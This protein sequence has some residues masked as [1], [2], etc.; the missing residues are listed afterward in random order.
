MQQKGAAVV[1]GAVA[2]VRHD[3]EIRLQLHDLLQRG[4]A[5]EIDA[6]FAG[7]ICQARLLEDRADKTVAAGHP[8]APRQWQHAKMP[9]ACE[10]ARLRNRGIEPRDFRS[11]PLGMTGDVAHL[12]DLL[13]HLAEC[14][15]HRQFDEIDAV[16]LQQ[17]PRRSLVELARGDDIG[18]QHQNVL[19]ASRQD[20]KFLRAFDPAQRPSRENRLKPMICAGSAS[21]SSIWS[22]QMFIDTMR[23]AAASD[24]PADIASATATSG[25]R[26]F[27]GCPPTAR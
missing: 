27:I 16:R 1:L 21:A 13:A 8:A 9:G 18:L 7:G 15:R 20:R 4:K 17:L 2:G 12:A 23:G 19:G 5:A 25:K 3:K 22:V 11:R 10:L 14:A 26:H 24:A 6:E